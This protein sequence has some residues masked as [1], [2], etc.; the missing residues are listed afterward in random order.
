MIVRHASD[1]SPQERA[2]IQAGVRAAIAQGRAAAA[3]ARAAARVAQSEAIRTAMAQ[4]RAAVAQGRA[5]AT[6]ARVAA[7]AAEAESVRAA[8]AAAREVN[9]PRVQAEIRAIAAQA[10]Q[11]ARS[12]VHLTA[13]Q[14]DEMRAEIH[15]RADRL[16][17][18]TR[19]HSCPN[20][21]ADHQSHSDDTQND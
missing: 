21:H 17:E 12:Q 20:D 15:A 3:E 6:E 19:N 4:S 5:V 14:R 11:L 8:V 9:S 7:R 1:L 2:R 16:R 18:I 13:E 10:A